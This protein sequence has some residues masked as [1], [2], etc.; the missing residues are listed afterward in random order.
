MDEG[1]LRDAVGLLNQLLETVP[2]FWTSADIVPLL[3]LCGGQDPSSPTANYL[4]PFVK[5]LARQ[6]PAEVMLRA[7]KQLW[8]EIKKGDDKERRS[9]HLFTVVREWTKSHQRSQVEDAA[10]DLFNMLL[11]AWDIIVST[12][13]TVQL[14]SVRI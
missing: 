8:A 3:S 7:V 5:R 11:E 12:E 2:D 6:I 14:P 4:Q 9:E 1:Q 10:R 13:L